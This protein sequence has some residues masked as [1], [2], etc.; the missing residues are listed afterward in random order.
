MNGRKTTVGL[1]MLCA[2]V[3]SAFAA[4][5]ANAITGTTAFTCKKVGP[6]EGQFTG[7][8]CIATQ[9][10][11]SWAHVPFAS[12]TTTTTTAN[13]EDEA[14]E[15]IPTIFKATVGGLPLEIE[16]KTVSGSGWMTNA[17]AAS[18]EHYVHK[19]S[20]FTF[21]E[22]IVK[23]PAGKGCKVYT[24]K[25]GEKGAEGVFHTTELLA[26]T[27]GQGMG[28]KFT[29]AAG[30]VFAT[31]VISGC[32]G[33]LGALNKTHSLTG[34]VVGTPAGGT[35]NFTHEATTSQNTLKLS[36]SK[37]GISASWTTKG[38]DPLIGGDEYRALSMT[39]V[40]TR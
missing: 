28:L 6:P 14:G 18:G 29:P 4:Q 26:T 40:S 34:S 35:T 11:A 3:F 32:E 15:K 20:L 8:H 30:E 38:K 33:G 10:D 7:S 17:I 23:S 36:G 9:P 37:A 16:A 12:N 21:E 22:A 5:S 39:T 24:D 25:E 31:F 19:A 27:E 2:L 13:N 1:C